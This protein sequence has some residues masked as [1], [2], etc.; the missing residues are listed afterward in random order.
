MG[1]TA[2]IGGLR[3]DLRNWHSTPHLVPLEDEPLE[4]EPRVDE[5]LGGE[6]DEGQARAACRTKMKGGGLEQV[7]EKDEHNTR[8]SELDDGATTKMKKAAARTPLLPPPSRQPKIRHGHRVDAALVPIYADWDG[9]KESL[10]SKPEPKHKPKPKIKSKFKFKP[11]PKS[12]PKPTPKPKFRSK[13]KRSRPVPGV[14][15]QLSI[16]TY[17]GASGTLNEACRAGDVALVRVLLCRNAHAVHFGLM[18]GDA[19]LMWASSSGHTECER[20]LIMAGDDVNHADR[21]MGDTALTKA[22]GSGYTECVRL[23]VE[24]GANVNFAWEGGTTVLMMASALG[25]LAVVSLLL[26]L[27]CAYG[28]SRWSTQLHYLEHIPPARVRQLLVGG[29]DVYVGDGS[30]DEKSTP[31]GIARALLARDPAHE[32]ASLVVAAAAPWSR[33]NHALLHAHVRARAAEL[34]RLGQLLFREER[35]AGKEGALLDV[36]PLVMAHALDRS[37]P[38]R[39]VLQSAL[40]G[41]SARIISQ[42]A[43][44]EFLLGLEGV[45]TAVSG[46]LES[47]DLELEDGVR[48][49]VPVASVEIKLAPTHQPVGTLRRFTATLGGYPG[50][51]ELNGHKL[52]LLKWVGPEGLWHVQLDRVD[53]NRLTM[54]IFPA[55]LLA[56]GWKWE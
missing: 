7:G 36:W 44:V 10:G 43:R 17:G 39:L 9:Y 35:F 14:L 50:S 3:V 53:H 24:A 38:T 4:D 26:E 29:A 51:P 1:E 40:A 56:L 21:Y 23:L 13:R 2:G 6:H 25:H 52:R 55:N 15:T 12:K 32:S 5:P 31:L 37:T 27:L 45:V 16:S 18:T 20:L 41:R 22:S 49:C 19:A 34:L 54:H 30:G 8:S 42:P 47:V 28:T 33:E 11:K 46:K 48:V